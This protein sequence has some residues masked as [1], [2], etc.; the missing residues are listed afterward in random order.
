MNCFQNAGSPPRPWCQPAPGS[1]QAAVPNQLVS[2]CRALTP[3][4]LV[5]GDVMFMQGVSWWELRWPCSQMSAGHRNPVQLP[6][7]PVQFYVS[8]TKK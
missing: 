2:P 1:W 3:G 6:A 4:E 7:C 8:E 5:R